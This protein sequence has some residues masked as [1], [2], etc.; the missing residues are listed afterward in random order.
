MVQKN[1][2]ISP[3]GYLFVPGP[4]FIPAM[5]RCKLCAKG[6][7]GLSLSTSMVISVFFPQQYGVLMLSFTKQL[8][9]AGEE[10]W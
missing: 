5:V 7:L 10:A 4:M 6:R 1:L 9:L 8:F 3:Q 2:K